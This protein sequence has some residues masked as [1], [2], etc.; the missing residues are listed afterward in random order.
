MLTI[1]DLP[2]ATEEIRQRMKEEMAKKEFADKR[3]KEIL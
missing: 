2:E 3:N 1:E